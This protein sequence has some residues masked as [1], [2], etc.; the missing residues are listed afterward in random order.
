MMSKEQV[1]FFVGSNS[2]ESEVIP[3]RL[4]EGDDALR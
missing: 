3:R 2:S 1:A 4:C